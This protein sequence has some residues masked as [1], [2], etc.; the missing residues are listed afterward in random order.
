MTI[1]TKSDVTA[2]FKRENGHVI[3]IGKKPLV[4]SVF[5]KYETSGL[6]IIEDNVTTLGIMNLNYDKKD[7]LFSVP[8]RITMSPSIIAL[9]KTN[10]VSY[11]DFTFEAG[12]IFIKDEIIVKENYIPYEI[13]RMF[14]FEGA[15]YPCL[16][17]NNVSRLFDSLYMTGF[18]VTVPV[19]IKS[20]MFSELHRSSID[21]T[22][23][24]RNTDMSAP[25]TVLG[26]KDVHLTASK[27]ITKISGSYLKSTLESAL[28]NKNKQ[29]SYI[30]NL[31]RR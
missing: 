3:Y 7:F 17:P 11:Y 23:L 1:N 15:R 4:A 27:F 19:G 28:V 2:L 10:D 9:R 22:I 30:E 5:E 26:S 31:L 18:N 24:Y 29:P 21:N 20:G 14:C 16:T 6:L 8:G 25:P 12:N 13:F